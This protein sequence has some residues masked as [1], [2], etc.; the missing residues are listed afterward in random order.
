MLQV[1]RLFVLCLEKRPVYRRQ[2]RIF[3]LIPPV[4]Y[5]YATEE[6]TNTQGDN[7]HEDGDDIIEDFPDNSDT[8]KETIK[9]DPG[10]KVKPEKEVKK[11]PPVRDKV[12]RNSVHAKRSNGNHRQKSK[13]EIQIMTT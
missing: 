6:P 5:G 11:S 4:P 3:S 12:K 1:Y 7:D 8:V 13:Y 10:I 9:E 2:S